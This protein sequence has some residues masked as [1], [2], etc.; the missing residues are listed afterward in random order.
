MMDSIYRVSRVILFLSVAATSLQAC[1]SD[2]DGELD[3]AVTPPPECLPQ[4]PR[5]PPTCNDDVGCTE[6]IPRTQTDAFV[7]ISRDLPHSL[8]CQLEGREINLHEVD[9]YCV[10]S[11]A[12]STPRPTHQKLCLPMLI[13]ERSATFAA[14]DV[15]LHRFAV[16]GSSQTTG[17]EPVDWRGA[18]WQ[19]SYAW[20]HEQAQRCHSLSDVSTADERSIEIEFRFLMNHWRSLQ[21]LKSPTLVVAM[22][23]D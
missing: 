23:P 5:D 21:G 9:G 19:I 4:E 16:N 14:L 3:T 7:W 22:T 17:L 18:D 13:H 11:F 20:Q 10:V 12:L 1:I 8:N 15:Q 6:A 2:E